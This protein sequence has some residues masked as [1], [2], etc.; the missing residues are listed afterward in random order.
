MPRYR[1]KAEDKCP[2]SIKTTKTPVKVYRHSYERYNAF[3]KQTEIF[4]NPFWKDVSERYGLLSDV[5][6]NVEPR[7]SLVFLCCYLSGVDW[8]PV[9][10]AENKNGVVRFRN[11]GKGT[12]CTIATVRNGRRFFLSHP[13]LVGEGGIER[14]FIPSNE[15]KE[16]VVVDRKYPLCSYTT[17]TWG[18]MKGGTF[19]GSMTNDFQDCDTIAMITTMP[20]GM[21]TIDCPST[22]KYRYLRYHAPVNNRS[23]LAE[24][25][26]FTS[27]AAG[28]IQLLQGTYFCSGAD[29]TMLD[30]AFDGNLSTICKGLRVGYTIGVDHG[31]RK[32]AV[33]KKIRFC[34]S[35]DLNFVEP[36]HLYELYCFDTEWHLVGRVFSK[37]SNLTFDHVPKGAILLLKDKS[38]GKE[39]RIFEYNNKQQIWH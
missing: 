18:F 24:L 15:E 3:I 19:E 9:A 11:V 22:K 1:I 36:S 4:S 34:P 2:Y 10:K 26:F 13:F 14:F 31:E 6:F 7:D 12:V 16:S 20:Y 8:M 25:Q 27:D 37:G 5:V 28:N 39:E 23:S 32:E 17:D 33:V 21:T 38:S 30:N 29:S 35:T